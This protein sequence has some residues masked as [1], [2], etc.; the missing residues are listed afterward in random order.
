MAGPAEPTVSAEARD[1]VVGVVATRVQLDADRDHHAERGRGDWW[2]NRPK[3][4]PAPVMTMTLP[5]T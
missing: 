5:S 1:H 4:L 3:P 2:A